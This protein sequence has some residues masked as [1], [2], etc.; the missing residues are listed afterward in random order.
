MLCIYLHVCMYV[1]MCISLFVCVYV[2]V[3]DKNFCSAP[4]CPKSYMPTVPQSTMMDQSYSIS[5][6][7]LNHVAPKWSNRSSK[8]GHLVFSLDQWCTIVV[9]QIPWCMCLCVYVCI[10]VCVCV[11]LRFMLWQHTV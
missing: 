11:C 9:Y 1:C 8:V 3:F 10:C 5:I 6:E 4:N 2:R 7:G